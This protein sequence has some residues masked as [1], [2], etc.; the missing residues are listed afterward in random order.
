MIQALNLSWWTLYCRQWLG[1]YLW[2]CDVILWLGTLV[3][4]DVANSHRK[5]IKLPCSC[6]EFTLHHK[7][8]CLEYKHRTIRR[9]A[10]IVRREWM[11]VFSPIIRR[12]SFTEKKLDCMQY[13]SLFGVLCNQRCFFC[14]QYKMLIMTPVFPM[15]YVGLNPTLLNISLLWWEILLR[16]DCH[17]G[18]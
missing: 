1:T 6:L 10:G 9:E 2:S 5:T 18:P 13:L 15:G 4:V 14:Y 8:H 7:K 16:W 3:V 12:H 17:S 11:C